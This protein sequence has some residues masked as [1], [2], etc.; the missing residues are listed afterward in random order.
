MPDP[1]ASLYDSTITHA[2]RI[3]ASKCNCEEVIQSLLL[4]AIVLAKSRV[5]CST[6][7]SVRRETL[8]QQSINIVL[9][10]NIAI[11]AEMLYSI[12]L[13]I[14]NHYLI[15]TCS[16]THKLLF[17]SH[18]ESTSNNKHSTSKHLYMGIHLHLHG[19]TPTPG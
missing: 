3:A 17:Q 19:Y 7:D 11:I 16:P 6:I 13:G 15:T 18:G 2:N 1:T 10:L 9:L 8:H 12:R 5:N 4:L 14:Y